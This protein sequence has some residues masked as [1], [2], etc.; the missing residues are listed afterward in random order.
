MQRI[1]RSRGAPPSTIDDAVQTAA[2]RS[3][4]RRDGF[5]TLQGWINWAVKVAWHDVQA[6]WKREAR[7]V[8][9]DAADR[10]GG[11]DP[12]T[13][14]EQQAELATALQGFDALTDAERRAIIQGLDDFVPSPPLPAHEKM[15]R[16]RARRRLA[17]IVA[18]WEEDRHR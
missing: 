8:L 13:V 2:E 16:Y 3:L 7:S 12:A 4:L 11:I 17:A 6:Q 18:D 10:P 14:V 1:L 9:G 5:D 15:R